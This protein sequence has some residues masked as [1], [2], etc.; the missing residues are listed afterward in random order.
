MFI[1]HK[2]IITTNSKGSRLVSREAWNCQLE[3]PLRL[4]SVRVSTEGSVLA[5]YAFIRL[6]GPTIRSYAAPFPLTLLTLGCVMQVPL[7]QNQWFSSLFAPLTPIKLLYALQVCPLK[8]QAAPG[9]GRPPP[10][11]PCGTKQP[12]K[13]PSLHQRRF[14]APIPHCSS[15]DYGARDEVGG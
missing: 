8:S 1:I 6:L 4:N 14:S 2:A 15:A 7:G 12:I 5:Q 13:P 3:V 9:R 11:R 10:P